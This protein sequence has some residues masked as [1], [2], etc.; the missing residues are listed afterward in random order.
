MRVPS[1][2]Q[3][4]LK[5]LGNCF[6]EYVGK[7]DMMMIIN[8]YNYITESRRVDRIQRVGEWTEYHKVSFLNVA[9]ATVTT[10]TTDITT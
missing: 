10:S 6:C 2:K 1:Q 3:H 7:I 4:R 8:L 9:I 5:G